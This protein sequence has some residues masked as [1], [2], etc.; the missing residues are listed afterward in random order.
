MK[1]ITSALTNEK[2][3]RATLSAADLI[4]KSYSTGPIF[5]ERPASSSI[6]QQIL[7][8]ENL[9]RDIVLIS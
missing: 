7:P 3:P 4:G 9:V 1:S 2:R 8:I 6:E 5:S